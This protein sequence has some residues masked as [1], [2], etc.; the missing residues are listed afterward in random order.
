MEPL[1]TH[2]EGG[3]CTLTLNR[4]DKRNAI[5]RPMLRALQ[6]A[7]FAAETDAAVRVVVL[8]GADSRAFSAGGDLAEFGHLQLDEVREWI[9]LGN[10]VFNQLEVLP[11]PTVAVLD[12]YVLGGG[13]ELALCCDFRLATAGATLGNPELANGWLPGWGGMTRLRRLLGE[14]RAKEVVLLAERL[15]ATE[16]Y[17]LGLLT[18]LCSP[19]DLDET[20]QQLLTRLLAPPSAML[21]MAKAAL[22][23]P[24]RQTTGP[25]LWFDTLAVYAAQQHL[26]L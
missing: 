5:G 10:T 17:R 8:R 22:Q 25:D 15:S 23:D 19:D 14:A 4:P 18:R 9:W 26:P 20:L 3:V 11:K 2:T 7:L 13:L 6:A 21:A 12:G 16:A 1:I 24:T